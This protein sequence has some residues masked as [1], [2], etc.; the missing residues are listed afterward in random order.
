MAE[1]EE[2]LALRAEASVVLFVVVL[3]LYLAEAVE[4]F[5]VV[6]F[7]VVVYHPVAVN[8][9]GLVDCLYPDP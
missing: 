4:P 5:V 2:V 3:A 6:A 8:Q 9:L 1:V 7:V